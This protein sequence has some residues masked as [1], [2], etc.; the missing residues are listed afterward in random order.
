[1]KMENFV[2][3]AIIFLNISIQIEA[4]EQLPTF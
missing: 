4:Q 1:M 2:N 3:I